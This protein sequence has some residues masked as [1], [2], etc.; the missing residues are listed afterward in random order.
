MVG[1]ENLQMSK[2]VGATSKCL[3]LP[4][5]EEKLEQIVRVNGEEEIN[6]VRDRARVIA[7]ELEMEVEFER[8]NKM[9]GALLFTNSTEILHSPWQLPEIQEHLLTLPA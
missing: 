8:L 4:E 6:K 3:T 7:K 9:I 5:L 1:E 2:Q